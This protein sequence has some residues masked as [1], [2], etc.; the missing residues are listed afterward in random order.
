MKF[1]TAGAY[2][3]FPMPF[4]AT[5][6]EDAAAAAAAV[7]AG[8]GGNPADKGTGKEGDQNGSV[9]FDAEKTFAD[10]DA[11][12]RGWLQKTNLATDPK[13]LA[14]KAFE[15]EKLLGSS[16]RV[17]GKD[18][19][20]E[21]RDAYLNK[22]GRPEKVD[23]YQ[24]APPKDMPEGLPYDGEF[25]TAFKAEAHKLGL[26]QDQATALHDMY[27]Q[28]QLGAFKGMAEAQQAANTTRA[29]KAT[30]ELTKL[31]GPLDGD[32]A[33]ANFE[34]AD[35]VFTDVKGGDQFLTALKEAGFVGP[36]KEIL[37]ARIAPFI[38]ALGT[39]LYTEDGVLRGRADVVGNPFAEGDGF[40]L[41][42]QSAI[43]KKDPGKARSLIAAAGKKPSDFGLTD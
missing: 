9:T 30:E 18:A 10:L 28:R 16:I 3:F 8:G 27:V 20:P 24:F 11:D 21:E 33:A 17:P 23:G 29:T 5:A 25:A 7:A 13:G 14:K 34:I 41:T 39:A 36:G 19:T 4:F 35:K 31:W 15:Q 40:N 42:E 1:L 43:V 32:T 2:P 12:T 6:E 38:A 22:L 26:S 37:D